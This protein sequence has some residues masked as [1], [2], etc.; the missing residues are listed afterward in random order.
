MLT[1]HFKDQLN[2]SS[3]AL[4]NFAAAL[5]NFAPSTRVR[6]GPI[7]SQ[8]ALR[9]LGWQSKD[10]SSSSFSFSFSSSFKW[11]MYLVPQKEADSYHSILLEVKET[12]QHLVKFSVLQVELGQC[13]T[14]VGLCWFAA[15]INSP[16]AA[17]PQRWSFNGTVPMLGYLALTSEFKTQL[18]R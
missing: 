17:D 2:C 13:V 10:D 12:S 14:G 8:Q 1:S 6:T 4:P 5:P 9:P 7:K 3:A 15:W 18:K 16:E 11:S